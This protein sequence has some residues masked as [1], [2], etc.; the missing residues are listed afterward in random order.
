MARLNW[1]SKIL[2]VH[3]KFLDTPCFAIAICLQR[4]VSFKD[5]MPLASGAGAAKRGRC[6]TRIYA[7][8]ENY[9]T[10]PL[11]VTCELTHL[12]V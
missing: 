4:L 12:S 3:V 5:A 8:L 1:C 10:E 2:F 9:D 7:D 11:C 6:K